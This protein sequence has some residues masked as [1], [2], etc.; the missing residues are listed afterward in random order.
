MS[1]AGMVSNLLLQ[2]T[3]PQIIKEFMGTLGSSFAA[4]ALFF[5]GELT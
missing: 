5:L 3:M 4:S 1:V 2:S